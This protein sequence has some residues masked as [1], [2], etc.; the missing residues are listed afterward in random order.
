MDRMFVMKSHLGLFS[1]LLSG[2]IYSAFVFRIS[3]GSP[4]T[5][6]DNYN[7][8]LLNYNVTNT[9]GHVIKSIKHLTPFSSI[10]INVMEIPTDV[11][12]IIVQT[13]AFQYDVTLSYNSS[14]E[15]HMYVNGTNIGL[16][17]VIDTGQIDT[18]LYLYNLN[19]NKTVTV[20][21]TVQAY[22]DDAPIPGG[23]NMEFSIETAPYLI[24]DFTESTVSVNS[25]PASAPV[26]RNKSPH[27]ETQVVEYE[28]YH[29]YL[30]ERDFTSL[31]YFDALQ[32]MM[33]VHDIQ[34]Y[35]RKVPE[36]S[37]GPKMRRIYSAYPGTGS[38][39]AIIAKSGTTASAY[40]PALTYSCNIAYWSDTCEVLNTTFSKVLCAMI[41]FL[42][43]FVCLSG[44]QYFKTEMFLLGFLSGSLV[45][46]ILIA[47]CTTLS[48][49]EIIIFSV[50]LG[51]CCGSFWLS[52]W[53]YYGIPVCSVLLATMTLGFII[54]GIFSYLWLGDLE[55][56]RHDLNYWLIYGCIILLVP[57][58]FSSII[59]KANMISCAVLG[60]YA[61]II[62]MDHYIGSNLKYIIVNVIRRAT[63]KDFRL[64]IIDPPFQIR[65]IILCSI[66]LALALIGNGIQ[67][68]KQRGKP[69]FPPP[70]YLRYRQRSQQRS[71]L[72]RFVPTEHTPL[73]IEASAPTDIDQLNP[74]AVRNPEMMQP[75]SNSFKFLAFLQIWK[76]R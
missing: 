73:L 61:V 11:R 45:A 25:Q 8:S 5:Q 60:A 22:G 13:H 33:T 54:A 49:S 29:M 6:E 14:L 18:K 75:P 44:H 32:K 28:M 56:L 24:L 52:L 43:L 67:W 58:L 76:R 26:P 40:V 72:Q 19:E 70:P 7:V 38:V 68:R 17:Q 31:T 51:M 53:W 74:H 57:I 16:V 23:C 15:P 59:H 34:L 21:V 12:F 9:A 62:P 42:G 47:L 66:W 20:L 10:T 36:S 30:E 4:V 39:Y 65:D 35:G 63:V 46:Y 64:A 27:C 55:L 3:Y 1:V 37:E 48:D 2:F 41:F 69:P 71:L 50:L